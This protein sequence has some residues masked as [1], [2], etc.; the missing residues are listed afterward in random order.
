MAEQ[1]TA[2]MVYDFDDV[3]TFP[4]D[5]QSQVLNEPYPVDASIIISK[6]RKMYSIK[7]NLTPCHT[8]RSQMESQHLFAVSEILF[9]SVLS[10]IIIVIKYLF[11]CWCFKCNACGGGQRETTSAHLI[12]IIQACLA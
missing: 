4:T 8:K 7:Q 5:E 10:L 9:Y 12:S 11:L 6:K 2:P 3:Y 1:A